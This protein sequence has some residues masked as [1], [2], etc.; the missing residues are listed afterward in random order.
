MVLMRI[1]LD[2]FYRDLAHRFI[3]FLRVL[4]QQ[5]FQLKPVIIW[6]P[7]GANKTLHA[8]TFQQDLSRFGLHY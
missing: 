7:T 4:C 2:L 3:V 8:L 1:R 5:C 6:P